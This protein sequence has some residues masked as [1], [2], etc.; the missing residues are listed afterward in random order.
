MLEKL[1]EKVNFS[2]IWLDMNELAN[3]CDGACQPPQGSYVFDY[4]KDIPYHPGD[5]NIEKSTISLNA[6][7]YGNLAEADVHAF[8]GFM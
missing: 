1:Y 5:S 2:G 6:T 3:F 4:S 8:F 7:H